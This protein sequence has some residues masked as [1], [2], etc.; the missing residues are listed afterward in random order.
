MT[1]KWSKSLEN[2]EAQFPKL[3]VFIRQKSIFRRYCIQNAKDGI[4]I[5]AY[6]IINDSVNLFSKF[7]PAKVKKNLRKSQA[8]FRE[9]LRKLRLRENNDFLIKIKRVHRENTS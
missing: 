5:H 6:N 4:Q 2:H 8:Q 7:I 9:M 3:N 1:V